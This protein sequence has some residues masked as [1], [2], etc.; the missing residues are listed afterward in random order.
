MTFAQDIILNNVLLD[1]PII[2][3]H[4]ALVLSLAIN[5]QLENTIDAS[6]RRRQD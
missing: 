3:E 4:W 2:T 1:E 6:C 5:L